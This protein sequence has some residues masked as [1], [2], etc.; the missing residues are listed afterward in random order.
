MDLQAQQED[1]FQA[2]LDKN[3][4]ILGKDLTLDQVDLTD[5]QPAQYVKN[6]SLTITVKQGYE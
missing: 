2:F 5:F 3:Q 1:V 4:D 6:G